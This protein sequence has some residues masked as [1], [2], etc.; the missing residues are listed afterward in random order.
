MSKARSASK[1]KATPKSDQ[2][3]LAEPLRDAAGPIRL[4]ERTPEDLEMNDLRELR[5]LQ[6]VLA[7][8]HYEVRERPRILA[9]IAKLRALLEEDRRAQLEAIMKDPSA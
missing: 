8:R 6:R 7:A 1:H 5:Y 9:E 4:P 3:F 2:P